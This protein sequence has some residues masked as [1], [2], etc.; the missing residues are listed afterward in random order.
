M[1]IF[2]IGALV[3]SLVSAIRKLTGLVAEPIIKGLAFAWAFVLVY[4]F[5]ADVMSK[6][7]LHPKNAM[8]EHFAVVINTIL[9]GLTAMGTHDFLDYLKAA[10]NKM[11]NGNGG[12]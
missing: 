5:G 12:S 1:D 4:W 6:I 11:K 2:L 10:K 3:R 9:I 7:G 8:A